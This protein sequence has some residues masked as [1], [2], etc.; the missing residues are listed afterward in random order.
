MWILTEATT[1]RILNCKQQ[2]TPRIQMY[3]AFLA[4]L[5][6]RATMT[7]PGEEG[8]NYGRWPYPPMPRDISDMPRSWF[9][10]EQ[11]L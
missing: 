10:T 9:V 5:G 4:K 11:K 3:T 6:W 2:G 7:Q 1:L 8:A